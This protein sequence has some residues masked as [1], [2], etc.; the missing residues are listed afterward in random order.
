MTPAFSIGTVTTLD[1]GS[2]ATVSISGTTENPVLNLGIPK[3][4]KGDGAYLPSDVLTE[5][6]LK[7][8]FQYVDGV[9][10]ITI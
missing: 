8:K 7:A 5:T 10:N 1:A 4:E 2:N 9:L 3:G 6:T